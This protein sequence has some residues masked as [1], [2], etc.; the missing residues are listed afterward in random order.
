M[1]ECHLELMNLLVVT[2]SSNNSSFQAAK[3]NPPLR[4]GDVV[5]YVNRKSV[6]GKNIEDIK[7]MLQSNK[8]GIELIIEPVRNSPSGP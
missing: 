6:Q 5:V 8:K 3:S 4:K 2:C 1:Y 7:E